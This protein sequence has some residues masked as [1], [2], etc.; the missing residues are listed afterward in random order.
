METLQAHQQRMLDERNELGI[1][2]LSLSTFL[3][4]ERF[5]ALGS[6]DQ[7]LMRM[8][9]AAMMQ[10]HFVLKQRILKFTLL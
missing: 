3:G 2:L 10:Y 1:R 9:H 6:D 7:C 4:S 5:N 8:Q